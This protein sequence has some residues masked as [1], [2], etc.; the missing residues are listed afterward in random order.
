VR[1]T[2]RLAGID[3]CPQEH[4][5]RRGVASARQERFSPPSVLFRFSQ[6]CH[7]KGALTVMK[8]NFEDG[9]DHSTVS[10]ASALGGPSG[11]KVERDLHRWAKHIY[12]FELEPDSIELQLPFRFGLE[13]FTLH[14]L[15][16]YW[17]LRP[18]RQQSVCRK[19]GPH[20]LR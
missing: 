3:I 8:A 2:Q 17:V 18:P 20:T 5:V 19:H 9:L 15:P 10:A 11:H 6:A 12:N 14:V 13:S 4:F 7:V 1:H 16:P